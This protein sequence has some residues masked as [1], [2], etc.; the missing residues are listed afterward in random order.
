MLGPRTCTF[1]LFDPRLICLLIQHS[2]PAHSPNSAKA[3]YI[4]STV[5]D[6]TYIQDNIANLF[7]VNSSIGYIGCH[8]DFHSLEPS[9][10][11]IDSIDGRLY[12]G[13]GFICNFIEAICTRPVLCCLCTGRC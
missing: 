2:C 10:R 5:P 3:M 11:S 9:H 6:G 1:Y 12:F 4:K 7:R 13:L 8:E